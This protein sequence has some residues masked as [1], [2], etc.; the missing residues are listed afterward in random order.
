MN[1]VNKIAVALVKAILLMISSLRFKLTQLIMVLS[2]QD[3][4]F[5]LGS[6]STYC[7]NKDRF[8]RRDQ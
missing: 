8:R 6:A 5:H 7:S 3:S 1:V 4:A 2:V